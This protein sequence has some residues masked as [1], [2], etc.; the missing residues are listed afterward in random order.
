MRKKEKKKEERRGGGGGGEIVCSLPC[1]DAQ[2]SPSVNQGY[3]P[4]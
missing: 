2:R 4:Y 3:G 1:E